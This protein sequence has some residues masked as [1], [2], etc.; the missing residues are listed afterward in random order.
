MHIKNKRMGRKHFGELQP[1]EIGLLTWA[2]KENI[3]YLVESDPETWTPETIAEA[4]PI[5]P[6]GVTKLTKSK[7]KLRTLLDVKQHDEKIMQ[8]IKGIT[9]GAI[10]MT[11]ELEK[12]LKIRELIPLKV[13]ELGV[14]GADH[15]INGQPPVLGEFASLVAPQNSVPNEKS[16]QRISDGDFCPEY[17]LKQQLTQ[18]ELRKMMHLGKRFTFREFEENMKKGKADSLSADMKYMLGINTSKDS[19]FEQSEPGDIKILEKRDYSSLPSKVQKYKT[20]DDT[21]KV[22]LNMEGGD[23]YVYKPESGY[24]VLVLLH[25]C[26]Q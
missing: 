22:N 23:A 18:D 14:N 6:E 4:Y 25:I 26:F 19:Q 12:R 2:E 24:E 11:E 10:P 7:V 13:G 3:R 16:V 15:L 17:D 21:G 8:K 9:S 1:K 5:S 20:P